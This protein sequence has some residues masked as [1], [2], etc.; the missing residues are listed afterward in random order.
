MLVNGHTGPT[1]EAAFSPDGRLLATAGEDGTARIWDASDGTELLT[2]TVN[3]AGLG[4]V[5]FFPNGRH[6]A[7]G[8]L[9]GFARVYT[10]DVDELRAIAESRVT[11][12]LT[13]EEC[14][15]FNFDPCP[16]DAAS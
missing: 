15:R 2:I 10:L 8:T 9:D 1:Q 12:S 14:V 5:D 13:T 6:V 3:S 7:V 4:A 16:S 11:R